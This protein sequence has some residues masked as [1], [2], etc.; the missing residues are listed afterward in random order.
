MAARVLAFA[1]WGVADWI[2][3][4]RIRRFL[5]WGRGWAGP[6]NGAAEVG[7]DGKVQPDRAIARLAKTS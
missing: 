4:D 1:V 3:V 7:M 5:R 2:L 6:G